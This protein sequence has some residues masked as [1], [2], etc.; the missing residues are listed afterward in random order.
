MSRSPRSGAP[1]PGVTCARRC[2]WNAGLA[3]ITWQSQARCWLSTR[4]LG[5]LY[6]PADLAYF[7]VARFR[8][9]TRTTNAMQVTVQEIVTMSA[10]SNPVFASTPPLVVFGPVVLVEEAALPL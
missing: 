4:P 8:F 6:A 5:R 10:I 9:H 2:S 7:V 3:P 1:I